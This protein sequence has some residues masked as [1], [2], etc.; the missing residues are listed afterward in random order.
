MRDKS[1]EAGHKGCHLAD[2]IFNR[3]FLNENEPISIEISLKCI[4]KVPIK[5]IQ[6]WFN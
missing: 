2:G 4:L 5:I 1:N 6:Y 3:I